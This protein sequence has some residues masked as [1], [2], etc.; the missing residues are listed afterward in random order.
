MSSL[1]AILLAIGA[2]ITAVTGL[3]ALF[4]HTRGPAHQPP[5][6][7]QPLARP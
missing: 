2:V 5:P 4:V 6:P 3:I 7:P 1:P